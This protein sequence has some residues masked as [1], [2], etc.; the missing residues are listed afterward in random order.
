MK[1]FLAKVWRIMRIKALRLY[2]K[3]NNRVN[4]DRGEITADQIMA[5]KILKKLMLSHESEMMIAPI[6]GTYYIQ[7]REIFAKIGDGRVQIINGKYFYD[8]ALTNRQTDD[9]VDFFR[10]RVELRRKAMEKEIMDKTMKSL[11]TIFSEIESEE[12]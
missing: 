8:I 12:S 1:P 10:H 2:V 7:R 9:V 3:I 4:E 11:K 5:V 6:S